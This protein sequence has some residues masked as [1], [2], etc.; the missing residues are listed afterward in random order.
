MPSIIT[1]AQFLLS[2]TPKIHSCIP[3]SQTTITPPNAVHKTHTAQPPSIPPCQPGCHASSIRHPPQSQ[4]LPPETGPP[5]PSHQRPHIDNLRSPSRVS[6][7]KKK[8]KKYPRTMPR[9]LF[10]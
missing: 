8:I 7:P 9:L 1:L 5:L 6:F 10:T 3:I 4:P 2:P